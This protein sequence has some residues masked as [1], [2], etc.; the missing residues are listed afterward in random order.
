MI[1]TICGAIFC[2]L[3]TFGGC[4]LFYYL[5]SDIIKEKI[6]YFQTTIKN[7]IILTQ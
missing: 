5:F 7:D 1:A 6:P 4:Y 3:T 2:L